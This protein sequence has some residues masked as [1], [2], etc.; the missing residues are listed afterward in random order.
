MKYKSDAMSAVI[1]KERAEKRELRQKLRQQK[2]RLDEARK[3]LTDRDLT[4]EWL[5]LLKKYRRPNR[6]NA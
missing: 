3:K 4:P 2:K 6:E 1:S 5:A